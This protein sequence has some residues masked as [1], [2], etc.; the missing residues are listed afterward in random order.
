VLSVS[1]Q[2]AGSPLEPEAGVSDLILIRAEFAH[3]TEEVNGAYQ[4]RTT[5]RAGYD[6]PNLVDGF[7]A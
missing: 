1:A 3:R 5:D 4:A 2:R 6:E 7:Y